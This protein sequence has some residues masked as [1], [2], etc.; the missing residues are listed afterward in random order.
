MQWVDSDNLVGVSN[1]Q[2][3]SAN[4]SRVSLLGGGR[5]KSRNRASCFW[6]LGV[7]FAMFTINFVCLFVNQICFFTR[8][9]TRL[10]LAELLAKQNESGT[11]HESN[12]CK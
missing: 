11:I 9:C 6:S 2:V 1:N 3:D 8:P 7:H 5:W 12:K 4:Q 10:N